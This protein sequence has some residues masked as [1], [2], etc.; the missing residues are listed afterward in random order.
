VKRSSQPAGAAGVSSLLIIPLCLIVL[1]DAMGFAMLG[2]ILA[3]RPLSDDPGTANILYGLAVGLYPLATFFA[4]PILGGFSDRIGRRPVLLFCG[5]GLA[6]SYVVIACGLEWQ[7]AAL[8][9]LGRTIGGLTAA[10]QAIALAALAD[11]GPAEGKDRRITHGLLA[12]SLGFVLGPVLSGSLSQLPYG[13]ISPLLVIIGMTVISLVWIAKVLPGGETA[14]TM[15][16]HDF[17][18]QF[19]QMAATFRSPVLRRLAW[20]FLLQ[21]LGWGTFFFFIAPYLIAVFGFSDQTENYY[22][23]TVGVGFCLSFGVVMPLLRKFFPARGIGIVCMAIA[24]VGMLGPVVLLF[25]AVAW[26]IAIPVATCAA[27]GYGALIMLFTDEAQNNEGEILGVTASINAL[28]FGL[29]AIFDGPIA[30]IIISG[31]I[32]VAALLM[33]AATLLLALPHPKP[34]TSST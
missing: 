27:A 20:V 22:M 17:G 4:A 23:A 14:A 7:S 2:P 30:A 31:P 11:I 9:L 33:L 32:F 24:T 10:T 5:C 1:I 26:A 12:S 16:R 25:P 19:R 29:A 15:E 28:A 3:A 18:K 8:I 34:L 13:H 21:Q 6:I